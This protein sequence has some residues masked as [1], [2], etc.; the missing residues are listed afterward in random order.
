MEPPPELGAGSFGPGGVGMTRRL[1]SVL[2]A[3][4]CAAC[5]CASPV[6][7][8]VDQAGSTIELVVDQELIVQRYSN[9]TTGYSWSYTCVPEDVITSLGAAQYTPESPALVGSGGVEAFSFRAVRAGR[10]TL[11]LEYRPPWERDVPST[12]DVVFYVLVRD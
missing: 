12:Q 3:A 4:A 8:T 9:P 5:G 6:V 2:L 7:V 1:A 10:A 11:R